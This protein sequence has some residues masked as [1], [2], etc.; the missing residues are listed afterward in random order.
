MT[1]HQ[2]SAAPPPMPPST[3]AKVPIQVANTRGSARPRGAALTVPPTSG[4]EGD[5]GGEGGEGES[6]AGPETQPTLWPWIVLLIQ[7]PYSLTCVMTCQGAGE[8]IQSP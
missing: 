1:Q 5:E 8:S 4:D 7:R 6:G 2:A 3:T